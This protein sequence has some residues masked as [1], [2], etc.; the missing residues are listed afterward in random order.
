MPS[1]AIRC[2]PEARVQRIADIAQI[3]ASLIAPASGPPRARAAMPDRGSTDART[4][5][6]SA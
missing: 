6:G 3:L 4:T 2:V 5:P 1:A